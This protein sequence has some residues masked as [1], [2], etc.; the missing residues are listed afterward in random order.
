MKLQIDQ[1]L[2]APKSFYLLYY[3]GLA[4]LT[5]F[6][7]LHYQDVGLTGRQIGVLIGLGPLVRLLGGPFWSA[8]ADLTRGHKV[9][10]LGSMIASIIAAYGISQA[11]A[12]TLFLMVTGAFGFFSAPIDALVDTAVLDMLGDRQEAYGQQRLWGAVG[13]GLAAP[14][15][16]SLGEQHGPIWHF[17]AFYVLSILTV[18]IAYSLRMG[19]TIRRAAFWKGLGSMASNRWWAV[20]LVTVFLGSLGRSASFGFFNLHLDNLGASRTLI[21]M[22]V[23]VAGFSE[24]PTFFYSG[25]LLRRYGARA[26]VLLSLGATLV[27]LLGFGIIVQP[28]LLVPLL[29]FQGP[30]FAA[31]YVAGVYYAGRAA[32]SGLEATTRALY[33][34]V[35]GLAMTV[36][37]FVGGYLYEVVGALVLFRVGAAAVAVAALFFL[38][39]RR[40]FDHVAS[41]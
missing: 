22:S 2:L 40:L 24:I 19:G 6:L 39:N 1:G 9:L 21:G 23:T 26:L 25:A 5:P 17:Y 12:F 13:W 8:I 36:G 28:E 18:P 31:I 34:A 7:T 20:F 15:V 11:R 32:P 14:L 16:G 38:A 29:I 4:A 27:M 41:D 37:G 33:G 35:G 30:G 10:L 3:G